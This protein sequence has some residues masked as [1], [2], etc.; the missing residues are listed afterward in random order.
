MNLTT[1]ESLCMLSDNDIDTIFRFTVRIATKKIR[2]F[3]LQLK[4]GTVEC[5][6]GN[7]PVKDF[8]ISIQELYI[9]QI[10]SFLPTHGIIAK[11]GKNGPTTISSSLKPGLYWSIDSIDGINALVNGQSSGISTGVCLFSNE[12]FISA[13]VGDVCTQEVFGF[14]VGKNTVYQYIDDSENRLMV[15]TKP[16]SQARLLLRALPRQHSDLVVE[17]VSHF[18]NFLIRGGGIS[19]WIISLWTGE[20]MAAVIPDSI[21]YPWERNPIYA[22]SLALGFVFLRPSKDGLAWNKY[23]PDPVFASRTV[24]HDILIIHGDIWKQICGEH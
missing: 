17:L 23:I 12:R 11:E 6:N 7:N 13:Y 5:G 19:S 3:R 2:E 1:P 22:I 15:N 8:S 24:P 18:D 10:K 4:N 9:K 20:A 14:C 16:L 21:E